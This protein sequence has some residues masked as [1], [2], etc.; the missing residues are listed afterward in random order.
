[1]TYWTREE[2]AE[3]LRISP[4]HLHD[5]VRE[6]DIPVLRI[7]RRVIFD[8]VAFAAVETACRSNSVAVPTLAP[9]GS[10]GPP[11]RSAHRKASDCVNVLALIAQRAHARK[12]RR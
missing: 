8:D 12:L 2:A 3:R 4:R 11:G 10:P 5:I 1:M 7:G 9:F 6:H